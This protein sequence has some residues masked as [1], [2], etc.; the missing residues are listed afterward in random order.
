VVVIAAL[1]A[2]LSPRSVTGMVSI[3]TVMSDAPTVSD[4]RACGITYKPARKK[5]D[6]T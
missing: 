1:F 6:W 2:A 3:M 5:T 4:A